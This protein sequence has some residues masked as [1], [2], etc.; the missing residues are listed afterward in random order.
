MTDLNTLRPEAKIIS[1]KER[2][3]SVALE[4]PVEFD[5]TTY[6]S[7]TIRRCSGKEVADF[8]SAAASGDVTHLKAPMIDCPPE[9]YDSMDDDDRL[10]LEEALLP[11]LPLR[12]TKATGLTQRITAVSSAQ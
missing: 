11:F 9:V 5:G 8:I 10:R 12:L 1:P 3:T 6:E 2:S 4:W 7:I